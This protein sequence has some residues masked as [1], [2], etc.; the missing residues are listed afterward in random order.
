MS[1]IF[2]NKIINLSY[3]EFHYVMHHHIEFIL[4]LHLLKI[5][6]TAKKIWIYFELL[7]Y[8]TLEFNL[9][10]YLQRD[11]L[12]SLVSDIFSYKYE[13]NMLFNICVWLFLFEKYINYFVSQIF[14]HFMVFTSFS[15]IF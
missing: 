12:F 2:R 13:I 9:D 5:N 4:L 3:T 8:Y 1:L 7:N 11:Q 15:C 6:Q 10:I 14:S